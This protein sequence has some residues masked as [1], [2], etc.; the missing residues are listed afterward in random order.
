EEKGAVTGTI[1]RFD[2][3]QALSIELDVEGEQRT[4]SVHPQAH[5]VKDGHEVQIAPLNRQFKGK[6][7]WQRFLAMFAGPAA[8][9][10]LAF[11]LFIVIGFTYGVPVNAPIFGEVLKGGPA[12]QAGLQSGDRVLSIQGQTINTWR[13]LVDI[14]S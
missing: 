10:L 13:E 4:F 2:L 12:A 14:V 3:E 5:L 8:N 6:T 11:V 7:I 1:V 9:F